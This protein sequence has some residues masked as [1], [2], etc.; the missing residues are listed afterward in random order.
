MLLLSCLPSA[1]S[2]AGESNG[3][4]L[5]VEDCPHK[6]CGLTDW[7]HATPVPEDDLWLLPRLPFLDRD[8]VD[9]C[10]GPFLL[11]VELRS[12]RAVVVLKAMVL[13]PAAVESVPKLLLA[14]PAD[15][16]DAGKSKSLFETSI[17]LCIVIMISCKRR[18]LW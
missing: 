12:S 6:A 4:E 16:V 14:I 10:C 8:V 7:M 9:R 13:A 11:V 3:I 17:G 5:G 15:D 2:S 18:E 1:A